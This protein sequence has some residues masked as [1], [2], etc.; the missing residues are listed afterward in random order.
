M[1]HREHEIRAFLCEQLRTLA[2]ASGVESV[3]FGD[4]FNLLESGLVD[5]VGLLSLLMR[6]EKE[7]GVPVDFTQVGPEEFGHLGRLVEA[8]ARS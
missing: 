7:L 1:T 5:S 3:E 6:V 8:L 2:D 4:D